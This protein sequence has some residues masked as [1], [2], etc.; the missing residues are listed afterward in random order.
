MREPYTVLRVYTVLT[1]WLLL[2]YRNSSSNNVPYPVRPPIPKDTEL[3]WLTRHPSQ[4]PYH[5]RKVVV[6][7]VAA[8]HPTHLADHT[9]PI[10]T[11]RPRLLLLLRLY[12]LTLNLEVV[13]ALV[14]LL[15]QPLPDLRHPATHT[16]HLHRHL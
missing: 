3:G 10:G 6:A 16:L 2:L 13:A 11:Q 4:V 1:S 8:T 7:A 12:G 14:R 5:L 15:M 9:N